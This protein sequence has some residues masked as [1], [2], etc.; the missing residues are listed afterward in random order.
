MHPSLQEA[1]FHHQSGRIDLAAQIYRQILA[2]EPGN[3]DAQH[4]LGVTYSQRAQY[5]EAVTAIEAALRLK[6]DEALYQHNLATS[7]RALG[8]F[9][10]S[11]HLYEQAITNKPEYAEAYFNYSAARRFSES[12]EDRRWLAAVED[13]LKQPSL[14]QEDQCFA[15]FAAGK[16]LNDMRRWDDAFVHIEAGNRLRGLTFDPDVHDQYIDQLIET[17]NAQFLAQPAIGVPDASPIFVVGMPRS[18]TTLVEQILA[19]HPNVFGAGELRDI[20]SIASTLPRHAGGVP[21]PQCVPPLP[22]AAIR[23]FAQS[24][25]RRTNELSGGAANVVDKMPLN[26]Q[27]LG[28]ISLMFPGVRIVHCRRDPLDT[29]VSCYFQRFRT[30]QEFSYR[31]DHLGR[32]Y[33]AYERLW[34][35]WKQALPQPVYE[36][37]Y[38]QLVQDPESQ[39]RKLLDYCRLPWDAGC[40][41]FHK[42]PRP[43]A[44]ASDM[45]VR[46]PLFKSA[47]GRWRRYEQHLGPLQEALEGPGPPE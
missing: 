30:S 7:L 36:L 25:L 20:S 27:H 3:A 32:A 24:Y 26:H 43:V 14:S 28:L 12:A 34:Q 1:V 39:V 18:G 44:T 5:A 45:Q 31:L 46:Q 4:L 40:L 33:R 6:P 13:L 16:I 2:D 23:G 42:N 47:I 37:Q 17:F 38:E 8:R 21:Y 29:C 19:T 15:H 10:E 35:H 22:P 9:E 41:E 11:N